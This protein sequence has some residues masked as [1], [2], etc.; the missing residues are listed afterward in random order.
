M[1]ATG[2]DDSLVRL[3]HYPC[4]VPKQVHKAYQGHSSHI[5]QVRFSKDDNFLVSTGGNDKCVLVWKTD[6]GAQ[7]LLKAQSKL[8][9]NVEEDLE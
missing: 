2:N 9:S 8:V 4:V 3:F 5:T 6:F 7:K 1:I